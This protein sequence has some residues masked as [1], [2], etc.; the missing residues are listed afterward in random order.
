MATELENFAAQ[1]VGYNP[2]A[3]DTTTQEPLTTK[4]NR[5]TEKKKDKLTKLNKS[6]EYNTKSAEEL[7]Y[8]FGQATSNP[9]QTREDGTQF[10]LKED[11]N[12]MFSKDWLG[13]FIEED[14]YGP[15]QNLYMDNTKDGNIKT[16][17]A[18]TRKGGFDARYDPAKGGWAPGEKGVTPEDGALMD[19]VLP[20]EL[21]QQTE[22]NI[23]TN[24]GQIA[25]RVGNRDEFGS[26]YTEYT[27]PD[28][29]LMNIN[30]E[31]VDKLGPVGY[32]MDKPDAL[33]R[34]EKIQALE[35][36][37]KT[38]EL[39]TVGGRLGNAL[40]SAGSTVAGAGYG[41]LD[42]GSELLGAATNGLIG[43]DLASD[44]EINSWANELTGYDDRFTQKAA[45]EIKTAYKQY[46]KDGDLVE[47][48]KDG[49]WA[50]LKA[51]PE[52]AASSLAFVATLFAPGKVL[53]GVSGLGK[54]IRL[55][56]AGMNAVDKATKT[57]EIMRNAKLV[58]K[59]AHTVKGQA[60]F[61]GVSASDTSS[62]M[63]AYKAEHNEDMS[64]SRV[65]GSMTVNMIK[66]NLDG[67][68][69][70][71]I[72]T[73]D[74]IGSKQ[75]LN[76]ISKADDGAKVALAKTLTAKGFGVAADT[77]IKEI[78]TEVLQAGAE[79]VSKQYKVG[80]DESIGDI[81]TSQETQEDMVVSAL[82]TP[83]S[84]AAMKTAGAVP[85]AVKTAGTA[86]NEKLVNITDS[87]PDP[88]NV[89]V[90]KTRDGRQNRWDSV[91]SEGYEVAPEA[92]PAHAYD[93][94]AL[95]TE[96]WTS[97]E[98]QKKAGYAGKPL[99][100]MKDATEKIAEIYGVDKTD[101]V[102]MDV[103]HA[104]LVRDA[105]RHMTSKGEDKV[106]VAT[107][108]EVDSM[109]NE[110]IKNQEVGMVTQSE[111]EQIYSNRVAEEID[112]LTESMTDEQ[113]A[114]IN[115]NTPLNADGLAK[116][117]AVLQDMRKL[118]SEPVTKYADKVE[119][120]LELYEKQ[121]GSEATKDGKPPKKT[122]QQVAD[123]IEFMGFV[124]RNSVGKS[125]RQ[126]EADVVGTIVSP[127]TKDEDAASGVVNELATFMHSRVGKLEGVTT[128]SKKVEGQKQRVKVKRL[129]TPQEIS[130]Y[131]M[132]QEAENSRMAEIAE[133]AIE[134]GNLTP[135]QLEKMTEAQTALNG[136]MESI[137]SIKEKLELKQYKS[138]YTELLS[139]ESAETVQ[140][141]TIVAELAKYE[142]TNI[143][144]ADESAPD[145]FADD[146]VDVESVIEQNDGDLGRAM[147]QVDADSTIPQEIKVEV[148]E[149]IR[150]KQDE[151]VINKEPEVVP[152]AKKQTELQELET[153]IKEPKIKVEKKVPAVM[154]GTTPVEVSARVF[155]IVKAG[156]VNG[157]LDNMQALQDMVDAGTLDNY[158]TYAEFK[159]SDDNINNPAEN[160]QI[161]KYKLRVAKKYL[162][163]T[164]DRVAGKKIHARL[165][166][167]PGAL[168]KAKTQYEEVMAEINDGVEYEPEATKL[169]REN[170]ELDL[171]YSTENTITP[172]VETVVEATK[173][174]EQVIIESIKDIEDQVVQVKA[175]KKLDAELVNGI[176]DEVQNDI[177]EY[178]VEL[179]Q[180]ESDKAAIQSRID[181]Y[182]NKLTMI[183]KM[184]K[185]AQ[186][187]KTLA[188]QTLVQRVWKLF[189]TAREV[190]GSLKKIIVQQK[191]NIRLAKEE[192]KEVNKKIK[193]VK[194]NIQIKKKA[195]E[196][197]KVEALGIPVV[198]GI[199][200]SKSGGVSAT[201]T[202]LNM[203]D[204]E[205]GLMKIMPRIIQNAGK[206][207][208][209][210]VKTA[211]KTLGTF[212]TDRANIPV[213]EQTNLAKLEL[214]DKNILIQSGMNDVLSDPANAELVK[215]AMDTTSLI[216]FSKAKAMMTY[217]R[218]QMHDLIDGSFGNL[219]PATGIVPESSKKMLES[220]IK[221]GELV[222][223][224]SLYESAGKT[225]L[226]EMGIKLD[227]SLIIEDKNAIEHSLGAMVL[228]NMLRTHSSHKNG[229]YRQNAFVQHGMVD[230][231]KPSADVRPGGVISVL[232]MEDVPS[233]YARVGSTLEFAQSSTTPTIDTE[234]IHT[235]K[236][237][238]ARKTSTE[239][240]DAAV[241][242]Q[243]RL[244]T[245]PWT[246]SE[247]AHK[248]LGQYA[249]DDDTIDVDKL[250]TD[251]LG[252]L[253]KIL[254]NTATM[255][256]ESVHAKYTADEL[257]IER[258]IEVYEMVGAGEFYIPYD[259][260]K[261]GRTMMDSMMLNPQNSK[262]SR[263]LVGAGDMT[264]TIE[265]GKVD[266][267]TMAFVRAGA[268]Q[269]L[270]MDIDK[271][272]DA[273]SI[274]KMSEKYFTIDDSAKITYSK[275]D[276]GKAFKKM[277]ETGTLQ[278]VNEWGG[279]HS[280]D[281]KLHTLQLVQMLNDLEKHGVATT[282]LA[283]EIDGITNGMSATLMQIGY[284]EATK[285][286][287]SKTGM[288]VDNYYDQYD[289]HGQY[290]EQGGKDIYQT[291]E[292]MVVDGLLKQEGGAKILAAMEEVLGGK[293]RNFMK[294]PVMVFIYGAGMTNIRQA[295]ARSLIV[296]NSYI[297][298]GMSKGA[299]DALQKLTG[300]T[301]AEL[302]IKYENKI[303]NP[304]NGQVQSEAQL[305][306][307][308]A[309]YDETI[310]SADK[311][312][313]YNKDTKKL[314]KAAEDKA[315]AEASKAPIAK[316]Q[317][318]LADRVAKGDT[319]V[320]YMEEETVNTLT[321]A[322]DEQV[323]EQ[324]ANAFT[325]EFG[326]VVKFRESVKL[327]EQLNYMVFRTEL[328]KKLAGLGATRISQL[329]QNQLDK[330]YAEMQKEGTYYSSNNA[331]GGQQELVKLE[332]T[333]ADTSKLSVQVRNAGFQ[334]G[335]G[336]TAVTLSNQVK[337]VVTNVGAVG[338]V[339]I[340]DVDGTVMIE[341]NTEDVLNVYDALMLGVNG[342][343][344]IL[345]A[346][347]MNKAFLD[348][349][350][351][352]SILGNAV[353]KLLKLKKDGKLNI[354]QA[355]ELIDFDET[356]SAM[357]RVYPDMKSV[358]QVAEALNSGDP[359]TEIGS[360]H[361]NR[362][363]MRGKK[364]K[365]N[366]YYATD[367]APAYEST[368][369]ETVNAVFDEN[370]KDEQITE[371][372][373]VLGQ[374][375]QNLRSKAKKQ[376]N[377]NR[378]N[379]ILQ[380][381]NETLGNIED[382]KLRKVLQTKFDQMQTQRLE[383]N[384]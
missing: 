284:T 314:A 111:I 297:P 120:G 176:I 279:A 180:L 169:L 352:H 198:E 191:E 291:P 283:L 337:D 258:M 69:D 237:K 156:K 133:A 270:D 265:A 306:K 14:Y 254:A 369:D 126:H 242:Y 187:Q 217:N 289:N 233:E 112:T 228:S 173:E 264:T 190:I 343:K 222:P 21:A 379:D 145:L 166:S 27:S 94:A 167:V 130:N 143:P 137:A 38:A 123:E 8:Q 160:K 354:K 322:I 59:I 95:A 22:Y 257:Q 48:I 353:Q 42:A 108:A 194:A 371:L 262:I 234:P 219:F 339:Q 223:A 52:A 261:S 230:F 241:A 218:D 221:R 26:G 55:E 214:N 87:Q 89:D 172:T 376:S 246:F 227:D 12:G 335:S 177:E 384:C 255:N 245:T 201:H 381:I 68:I 47:L 359:L 308:V 96:I 268:A 117:K 11:A 210:R 44:E 182:K 140:L 71:K 128:Q 356:E 65:M 220:K 46:Q 134:S 305:A 67:F 205:A 74:G 75:I 50:G 240:S 178:T 6:V 185:S 325:T 113:K 197:V 35:E 33:V 271:L 88:T 374:F 336:S 2:E 84:V 179:N 243:E 122:A 368:G 200:K 383:E 174:T 98:I 281:E 81:L 25:S 347:A 142:D 51:A 309:K 183:S 157:S 118:G 63:D 110:M 70:K 330:V 9:V 382:K 141:D 370:T 29:P 18:N 372:G 97:P 121:L 274:A 148:A 310:A 235:K 357:K 31:Q 64:A 323:G 7:Q 365:S 269:A 163:Y 294:G 184:L 170:P 277:V 168:E 303:Y 225:L 136:E 296:G 349:N 106:R 175:G 1:A 211:L 224:A 272:E 324:L 62:D 378:R 373:D 351:R 226:T 248:V 54:V 311:M 340:H 332:K 362:V 132:S 115:E 249:K 333:D 79:A 292:T 207:G 149:K 295:A 57:K 229:V 346:Q 215:G 212:S 273:T 256:A 327:I 299:T 188:P 328:N 34:A 342:E 285:L 24:A 58:D 60:G 204:K 80:G 318:Q 78:P 360:I 101:K 155:K 161:P 364:V 32:V 334:T 276:S 236:G 158:D 298:G 288:Y 363:A 15:T 250:K 72:I 331:S 355:L 267:E 319:T 232:M 251:I 195:Q 199:T 315:E 263:F 252:D 41:I 131:I 23:H 367:I 301:A 150:K 129:R 85:K 350:M 30:A 202:V 247:Q 91:G 326:E 164:Q 28:S 253:D 17:L 43:G 280:I 36:A 165:F 138:M 82:M 99:D 375:A 320:R 341:G 278:A 152:T 83:G 345:Q 193:S 209:E 260:T 3:Y 76:L 49:G 244:G 380:S 105:V 208:V 287:L 16:G 290:K 40:A 53:Q 45:E 114:E 135:A 162:K 338:V 307:E 300:K 286:H 329:T 125:L 147:A 109:L 154:V 377:S 181:Q 10:R 139:K 103:L 61:I 73:A 151:V 124:K 213:L 5:L 4:A 159:D 358:N 13:N 104:G 192:I 275:S 127:L 293:W 196:M 344:G 107:D 312:L 239:M 92:A 66:N 39:N 266:K 186:N 171:V 304:D 116:V 321:N 348:I 20:K 56:T 146:T 361:D 19:M 316:L 238:K 259:Y 77:V 231:E 366:Q 153:L 90:S 203:K 119:D 317:K 144:Q 37:E 93:M 313:K 102:A 86:A 216:M 302:E 189:K 206:K 100:A 282:N